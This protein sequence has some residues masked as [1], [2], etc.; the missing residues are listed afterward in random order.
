MVCRAA[1]MP[2]WKAG[3][4]KWQLG[5]QL[6][7][8]RI[9]DCGPQGLR[10]YRSRFQSYRGKTQKY[11]LC[12]EVAPWGRKN[13]SILLKWY[14]FLNVIFLFI[15]FICPSSP[16]CSPTPHL[17]WKCI[18]SKIFRVTYFNGPLSGPVYCCVN[19]I[20]INKILACTPKMWI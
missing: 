14:F 19:L 7:E 5:K 15:F 17:P 18:S 16:H 11:R 8:S 13:S 2:G 6:E 9:T 3:K 10:L 12:Q 4:A 20:A 1:V